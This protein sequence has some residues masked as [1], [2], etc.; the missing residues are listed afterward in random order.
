MRRLIW[1]ALMTLLAT[2]GW[3]QVLTT[4]EP[5]PWNVIT[6][7]EPGDPRNNTCLHG[8]GPDALF[9]V[10]T[11]WTLGRT[12]QTKVSDETLLGDFGRA[13]N[14]EFMVKV[15]DGCSINGYWWVFIGGVTDQYLH[16]SVR[17]LRAER[18]L[19]YVH[20]GG[21]P[22]SGVNNTRAFPCRSL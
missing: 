22:L 5:V 10:E 20:Y 7:P 14:L 3:G 9:E 6:C 13:E 15:L 12:F 1:V 11:H 2:A 16:I 4:P 8:D 19:I 21:A 18:Q 17:D